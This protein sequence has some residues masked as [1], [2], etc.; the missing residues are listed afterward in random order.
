MKTEIICIT[1][2]SGSMGTLRNDVIGGFNS[3]VEEQRA[4]PGEA[5][6]TLV[7]F[8]TVYELNYQAVDL[9]DV[10]PL[11][12]QTYQPRGMTALYDAVGRTLQTQGKRIHDE[13]WADLV[14]VQII[15]DG[16]ENSSVEF[17]GTTVTRMVE[18]AE[19]NG[20]K[21]LYLAAN[22]DAKATGAAI[23]IAGQ[24]T[25]QYAATGQGVGQAY[26]STSAVMRSL[27]TG[28]Q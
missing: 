27:R 5:R 23:G 6:L 18:H 25:V 2:R 3:F 9:K 13:K 10:K 21:F 24:N 22:V 12:Y 11:D 4:V 19:R 14:I 28:V 26:A 15:T 20:W 8:D 1:D 17:T 16:A 7:Q